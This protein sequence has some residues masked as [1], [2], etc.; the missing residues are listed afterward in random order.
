MQ[1]GNG[2]SKT[3]VNRKQHRQGRAAISQSSAAGAGSLSS[4]DDE[5]GL[6][7][8][9]GDVAEVDTSSEHAKPFNDKNIPTFLDRAFRMIERTSDNVVCW[10]DGGDSFI[11]KQA[12]EAREASPTEMTLSMCVRS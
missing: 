9:A 12:R 10:S 11:I 1:L 8:G 6:E 2:N 7:P 5:S 4:D 3:E